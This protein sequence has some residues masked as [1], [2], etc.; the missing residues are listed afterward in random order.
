MSTRPSDCVTVGLLEPMP[1]R[2]IFLPARNERLLATCRARTRAIGRTVYSVLDAG[3]EFVGLR[4]PHYILEPVIAEAVELREMVDRLFPRMPQER[5]VAF[6]EWFEGTGIERRVGSRWDAV[7]RAVFAFV[8]RAESGEVVRDGRVWRRR[9]RDRG[10]EEIVRAWGFT[11]ARAGR[12]NRG[13]CRGLGVPGAASCEYLGCRRRR[14]R[15]LG[16][17]RMSEADR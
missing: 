16:T 6:F 4:V 13:A 15:R 8:R 2:Y 17:D 7:M 1:H 12:R 11:G 9:R 3:G 14:R 5:R 10:V